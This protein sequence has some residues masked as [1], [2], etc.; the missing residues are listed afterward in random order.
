MKRL[1]IYLLIL[2][3]L[4]ACQSQ[5][6]GPESSMKVKPEV[7]DTFRFTN[8]EIPE[9]RK[10]IDETLSIYTVVNKNHEF[11][12][13]PHDTEYGK[14]DVIPLVE[15]NRFDYYVRL[16]TGNYRKVFQKWLDRSNEYIYIVR[17]IL[18]REGVPEELVYLPFTESGFNP[19][20]RSHAGA[21][22]MWQFM[23]G[24]G[25]IYDLDV[26]FWVDE[27]NDFEKSTVAAARHL[28][29]L[30]DRLGDW[31]L[32]MA[33]Y[34]AGLGKVLNAIKRYKTRDFF[35]M[36]QRKYRYLKLE[37][38]DYV[39]K[40]LA[41]RYLAR[42]YQEFGFET[43]S[44]QPQL[45]ERVTLYRQAN[46]YIIASLI[47]EDIETLREMNPELMTPMTPPVEEYS[48]RIPYGKKQQLEEELEHITDEELAQFH[49][50][51][52]RKGRSVSSFAKKYGMS[53]RELKRINGLR[54][55]NILRDT[56]LFIPI[57]EVYDEEL[58]S[59]FVQELKRYNPKV[60]TVRRGDNM[61]AI[62]HKYGMSLY[63][64]MALNRGVKP[65][66]IRPGQTIIVSDSYYNSRARRKAPSRTYASKSANRGSYTE[67]SHKVRSG[68]SLWSIANKYGTTISQIKSMNGLRG[69]TIQRGK[70]LKVRN[71]KAASSSKRTASNGKYTVRY[72]DSLWAI[73]KKFGTSVNR[74]KQKNNLRGNNIHPGSVLV[75]D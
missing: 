6:A 60:H 71:Y 33:A 1:F 21:A 24:T 48:L 35:V 70:W 45:F 15:N 44:G 13:G 4:A 28:R 67:L 36:S 29:D 18:R 50:E 27:R 40:Y 41:L 26:D 51:F 65:N 66:K 52:A 10:Q 68:E 22:G 53:T 14:Y 74:I 38:K 31:Y 56:Y 34:N 57:K 72:G 75:I 61:Y 63:E 47:G 37:T 59:M 25:R 11:R 5:V 54:H 49:V 23:K 39:P 8:Y 64:L 16:F 9:F 43:P 32:A 42:N 55:N 3:S 20:I 69:N 2:A 73:A 58:N 62:A 12:F 7:K 46:L 19:S 30:H 17:D